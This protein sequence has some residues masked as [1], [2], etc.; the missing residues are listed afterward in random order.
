MG[1]GLGRSSAR[2]PVDDRKLKRVRAAQIGLHEF[3][4]NRKGQKAVW[5]RKA[6]ADQEG[7]EGGSCE[8]DQNVLYELLKEIKK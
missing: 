8:Y 3:K 7:V 1:V 5:V 2:Q 4:K 6:G